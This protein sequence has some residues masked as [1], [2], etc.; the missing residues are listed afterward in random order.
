[1]CDPLYP[2]VPAEQ[3]LLLTYRKPA[4]A[5][6]SATAAVPGSAG[7]RAVVRRASA[8][9][10]AEPAVTF[11]GVPFLMVLDLRV[12]DL[13]GNRPRRVRARGDG[14]SPKR[15]ETRKELVFP[16]PVHGVDIDHIKKLL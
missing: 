5:V 10:L 7:S 6:P 14:H 2:G 16:L 1:V 8:A 12:R 15:T 9:N 11:T 13:S 4:A 3:L